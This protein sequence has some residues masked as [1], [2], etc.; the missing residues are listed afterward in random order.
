[1]NRKFLQL[2]I[3]PLLMLF[4]GCNNAANVDW[5]GSYLYEHEV[6][7]GAGGIV[8]II[9]YTLTMS[10]EKCSL[11]I[12]GLQ[13]DEQIICSTKTSGDSV[14]VDFKSYADGATVNP[15]GVAVYTVGGT[16]FSLQKDKS[17]YITKWQTLV[18]DGI[19]ESSGKYFAPTK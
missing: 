4:A 19:K 14:A 13:S 12:I 16:L 18:P 9:E 3:F 5:R 7:E 15:V 10:D 8:G 2:F 17:G 1:M 6:G 11:T